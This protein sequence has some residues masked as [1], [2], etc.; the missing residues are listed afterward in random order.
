MREVGSG[1]CQVAGGELGA[2]CLLGARRWVL[3]MLPAAR[4]PCLPGG[5]GSLQVSFE[6]NGKVQFLTVPALPIS[7]GFRR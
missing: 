3:E 4:Q 6:G 1:D 5:G 7:G 2:R